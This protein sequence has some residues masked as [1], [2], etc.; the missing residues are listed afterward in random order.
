VRERKRERERQRKRQRETDSHRGR[1]TEKGVYV[2]V[3]VRERERRERE[4]EGEREFL[5][6]LVPIL[7]T[8]Y[9]GDSYLIKTLFICLYLMRVWRERRELMPVKTSASNRPIFKSVNS[10]ILELINII[11]D[12]LT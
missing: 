11:K 1:E 4:R 8:V 3:C 12:V 9:N 2:C 6:S 7:Q 10:R 5:E